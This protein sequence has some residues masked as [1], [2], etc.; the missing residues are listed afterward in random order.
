MLGGFGLLQNAGWVAFFLSLRVPN[1][2]L[3]DTGSLDGFAKE[4]PKP[5]PRF[6][7]SVGD[8][9]LVSLL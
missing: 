6:V 8:C 1:P 4:P 9:L 7:N 3:N 5:V 2:L